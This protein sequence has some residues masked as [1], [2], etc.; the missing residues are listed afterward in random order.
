MIKVTAR[1]LRAIQDILSRWAPGV[2]VRAFGSRVGGKPK[3][4]SDLDL[5]LVGPA[6]LGIAKLASLKEAFE[7]SDLPFRVDLIDWHSISEEFRKVISK[8][9]EVLPPAPVHGRA[10]VR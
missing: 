6:R 8:R 10:A 5:V 3:D 2:P 4:Y 7:E 1:Q 9:S